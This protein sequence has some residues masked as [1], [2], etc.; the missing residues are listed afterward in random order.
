MLHYCVVFILDSIDVFMA[1]LHQMEY[2]IDTIMPSFLSALEA[3][4]IVYFVSIKKYVHRITTT[5]TNFTL[6][7]LKSRNIPGVFTNIHWFILPWI[8]LCVFHILVCICEPYFISQN[9]W[10]YLKKEA[11]KPLFW[12]RL[13]VNLVVYISHWMGHILWFRECQK[14]ILIVNLCFTVT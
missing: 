5:T 6:L 3:V 4:Y 11:S 1:T 14:Q 13:W 12:L 9:G 7:V 2:I 8:H 10:Q